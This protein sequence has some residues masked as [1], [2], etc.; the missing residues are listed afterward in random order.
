[1]EIKDISKQFRVYLA[2]HFEFQTDAAEHFDVT[3][4]FISAVARGRKDPTR[5]MLEAMGV[6]KVRETTVKYVTK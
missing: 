3:P 1:M 4:Q 2:E 5:Q 6:N